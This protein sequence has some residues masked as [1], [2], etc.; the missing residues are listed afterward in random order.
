G[1][2]PAARGWS[3]HLQSQSQYLRVAD[4]CRLRADERVRW[5]RHLQVLRREERVRP[6]RLAGHAR[7]P[8]S[9]TARLHLGA[10][11]QA[12]I[13]VA[14]RSRRTRG[15]GAKTPHG[16]PQGG[17]RGGFLEVAANA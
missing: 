1:W 8:A 9:T 17:T 11:Q 4:Y 16:L 12:R 3:P 6:G 5:A 15:D 10:R 2:L 14:A 13:R 7:R